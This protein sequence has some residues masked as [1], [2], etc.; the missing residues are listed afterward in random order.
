MPCPAEQEISSPIIKILVLIWV[1]MGQNNFLISFLP[2]LSVCTAFLFHLLW[3]GLFRGGAGR[4]QSWEPR[5]A[6]CLW[7]FPREQNCFLLHNSTARIP[8]LNFLF[9]KRRNKLFDAQLKDTCFGGETVPIKRT[10]VDWETDHA[11]NATYFLD[12]WVTSW[13]VTYLQK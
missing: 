3:W 9:R 2:F 4:W 8:L 1:K 6:F 10:R 11:L 12:L 13:E 5:H 7:T